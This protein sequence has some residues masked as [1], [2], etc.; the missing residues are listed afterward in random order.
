M[1]QGYASTPGQRSGSFVANQSD[2]HFR[3][4]ADGRGSDPISTIGASSIWRNRE[5]VARRQQHAMLVH[6]GGERRVFAGDLGGEPFLRRVEMLDD[7]ESDVAVGRHR[8]KEF[9]NGFEPA[10]EALILKT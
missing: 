10:A 2:R 8:G 4:G 7:D 1:S 3:P 6:A 9:A 5:D